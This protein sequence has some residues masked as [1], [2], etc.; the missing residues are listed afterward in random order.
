MFRS[1]IDM[2]GIRMVLNRIR[3]LTAKDPG[4]LV[5][6][7]LKLGEE[8]GELA[9]AIL[10][11]TR[12]PSSSYRSVGKEKLLEE[13]VDSIMVAFSVLHHKGINYTDKE[14]IDMFN[15]KLDK[16]ESILNKINN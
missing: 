13:A 11:Y 7:G 3:N 16:W 1:L 2:V 4:D 15:K 9:Q 5:R 8:A 10:I 14:I 6:R 12:D